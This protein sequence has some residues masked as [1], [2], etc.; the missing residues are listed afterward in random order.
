MDIYDA[1]KQPTLV[2][3]DDA[4]Y[5][6][7]IAFGRKETALLEDHFGFDSKALFKELASIPSSRQT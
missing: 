7:Y 3:D 5:S 4:S 1:R 6:N 2:D